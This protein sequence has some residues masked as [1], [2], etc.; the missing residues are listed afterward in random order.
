MDAHLNLAGMNKQWGLP[1]AA[2]VPPPW[3]R[4]LLSSAD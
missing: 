2:E 3:R 4:S 1:R